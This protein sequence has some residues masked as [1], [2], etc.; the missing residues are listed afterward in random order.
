MDVPFE[1]YVVDAWKD[2]CDEYDTLELRKRCAGNA[3]VY[4][5]ASSATLFF[6]LAAIAVA[7]KPSANREAW[8][9]K[10]VLFFFLVLATCFIPN[11]PLFSPI[12]MNIARAGSVIY[13]LLQQVIFIDMAYNWNDSWVIKA[14]TAETEETGT[15]KK[16]LIAILISCMILFLGSIVIIALLFVYFGGC[17]TNEAFIAITLIMSVVVTAVQLSGEEGSLLS[18]AVI[19]SYSTYICYVAGT[20]GIPTTSILYT[21]ATFC[22]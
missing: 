10:Y 20:C 3:G 8:P 5:A 21:Y 11:E 22:F 19:V 7:C 14:D 2:G 6:V 13:I 12:Y 17:A 15:G 16:W 9:A 18:S 4:R 1:N